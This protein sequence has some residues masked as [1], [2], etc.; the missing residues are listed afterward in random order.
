MVLKYKTPFYLYNRIRFRTNI[1]NLN[2]RF[3]G[4]SIPQHRLEIYKRS[5]SYKVSRIF[6]GLRDGIG[7]IT[8]SFEYFKKKLRCLSVSVGARIK[9]RTIFIVSLL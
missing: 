5:F 4:I 3:W 2:L 7:S 8:E 6:N 9:S 1:H